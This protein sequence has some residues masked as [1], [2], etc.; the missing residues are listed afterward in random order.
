MLSVLGEGA[1][2]PPPG[3]GAATPPPPPH[4]DP[5]EV[6]PPPCSSRRD[7][8]HSRDPQA[9]LPARSRPATR[10]RRRAGSRRRRWL[11]L[12]ACLAAVWWPRSRC[13]S[14]TQSMRPPYPPTTPPRG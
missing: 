1:A 8:E 11:E 3:G 9:R 13:R 4:E 10:R 12:Q 2:P 5:G 14:R 7:L 6:S